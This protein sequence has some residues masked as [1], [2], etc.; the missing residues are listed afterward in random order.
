M[1][2]SILYTIKWYHVL[3]PVIIALCLI[4]IPHIVEW[5]MNKHGRTVKDAHFVNPSWIT[6]SVFFA[7]CVFIFMIDGDLLMSFGAKTIF[8]ATA[9]IG[10]AHGITPIL[11]RYFKTS[12]FKMSGGE[13]PSLEIKGTNTN[14]TELNI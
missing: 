11:A 5:L 3:T 7:F 8:I 2:S 10:T 13:L 6:L 9:A 4:Y 14:S 12:S 1:E